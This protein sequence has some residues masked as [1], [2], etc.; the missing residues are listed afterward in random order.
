MDLLLPQRLPKLGGLGAVETAEADDDQ[1]VDAR[2]AS[3]EIIDEEILDELAHGGFGPRSGC[4]IGGG[5]E[6]AGEE[7]NGRG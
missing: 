7:R 3:L 5:T 1:V 6:Q 4:V 2:E